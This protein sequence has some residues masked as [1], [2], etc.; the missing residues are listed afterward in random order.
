MTR[1]PVIRSAL[2]AL[3]ATALSCNVGTEGTSKLAPHDAVTF[4][5]HVQPYLELTCATL[6]CHGNRGRALRLYSELGLRT[7]DALR[8]QPIDGTHEPSGITQ[9]ELDA[10]VLAFAAIA[11]EAK[12]P[13]QHLALL[14]PLA[15]AAGGIQHVGGVHWSST[16][17][18]GYLCLRAWLVADVK[19]DVGSSCARAV[20]A[21]KPPGM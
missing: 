4:A 11:I 21:V 2:A 7:S 5:A 1:M 3:A 6:D 14:K 8:A 13:S 15:P 12:T 17:D 10:N 19:D 18:P 20:D 9:A 16:K